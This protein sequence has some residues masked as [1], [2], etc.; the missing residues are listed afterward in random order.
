VQER[1]RSLYG[2]DAAILP[3]PQ[4][5]GPEGAT[6]PVGGVEPGFFLCVAR[7][8]PYKNVDRVVQAFTHL[9][10]RLMVVGV[11]PQDGAV[12]AL[13]APNVHVLGVVSDDELRWLY[14]NAAGLISASHEDFGLTP[15]EAASFGK[16]C[17]VLRAGGFLDT[18]REGATGLFFESPC[19]DHIASAVRALRCRR[20]N[21]VLIRAHA[22]AFDETRFVDRLRRLVLEG[23]Q[24]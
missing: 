10:E 7:L 14:A 8:L 9:D 11:G 12:R 16:P 21:E 23:S 22:A 15:L 18:L 2:I 13:A 3:P 20:W 5:V 1:I 24:E 17:A 4:T 19:P 6:T